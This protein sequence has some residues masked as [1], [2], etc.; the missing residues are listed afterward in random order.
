[1][2]AFKDDLQH[3]KKYGEAIVEFRGISDIP[4]SVLKRIAKLVECEDEPE[5]KNNFLSQDFSLD[6][7]SKVKRKFKNDQY[8]LQT[9]AEGLFLYITALLTGRL[10]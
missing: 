1:M 4:E 10:S 5:M 3:D 7:K 9:Q 2:G 8:D 6:V